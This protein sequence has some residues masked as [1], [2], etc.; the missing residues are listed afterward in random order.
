MA[1]IK[2]CP[3]C[4][5]SGLETNKYCAHCGSILS[6]NDIVEVDTPTLASTTPPEA[7]LVPD[8]AVLPS[9]ETSPAADPVAESVSQP[10]VVPP[11]P[12]PLAEQ[13]NVARPTSGAQLMYPVPPP[14]QYPETH[15]SPKGGSITSK[16]ILGCFGTLLAVAC[17]GSLIATQSSSYPGTTP[18]DAFAQWLRNFAGIFGGSLGVFLLFCC[19]FIPLIFWIWALIDCITNE[20]SNTN[21]KIVWVILIVVTNFIG[22][23][24]YVI[25]RR[26]ER[27]QLAAK[28]R[29]RWPR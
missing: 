27:Q 20:P 25:I 29:L 19:P 23:L 21:D 9:A 24:L 17:L 14:P 6:E 16:I 28:D 7:G 3:K 12:T 4:G 10:T 2:V 13:Q 22:A 1:R 5:G 15:Y 26:P 18:I 11:V 8:T